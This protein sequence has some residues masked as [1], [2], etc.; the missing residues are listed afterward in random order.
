MKWGD[1]AFGTFVGLGIMFFL[2]AS[3]CG[4][5]T[6]LMHDQCQR[7]HIKVEKIINE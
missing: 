1:T 5:A 2:F 7:P 4:L 6:R 3:G